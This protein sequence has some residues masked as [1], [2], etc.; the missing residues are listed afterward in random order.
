MASSKHRNI[1]KR[2]LGTNDRDRSDRGRGR[3]ELTNDIDKFADIYVENV[4]SSNSQ[5]ELEV[6]FGTLGFRTLTHTDH[7][8]VIDRILAAGYRPI[9]TGDYHLRIHYE[10]ESV[11]DAISEAKI[12]RFGN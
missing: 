9:G 2:E 11:D 1:T 8:N 3:T 7:S 10:N 5:L 4:A 12:D 6:R